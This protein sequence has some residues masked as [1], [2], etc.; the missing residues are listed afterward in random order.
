MGGYDEDDDHEE[1]EDR[2]EGELRLPRPH[3]YSND[4]LLE[5]NDGDA[6]RGGG[7]ALMDDDD[8]N[9]NVDND[10]DYRGED[11]R[12]FRRRSNSHSDYSG[13]GGGGRNHNNRHVHGRSRSR[14]PRGGGIRSSAHGGQHAAHP[15][16]RNRGEQR[17]YHGRR[18]DNRRYGYGEQF[19]GRDAVH[20]AQMVVEDINRRHQAQARHHGGDRGDPAYQAQA[21]I[22]AINRRLTSDATRQRHS[23][24]RPMQ[25]DVGEPSSGWQPPSRHHVMTNLTLR[26]NFQ[27]GLVNGSLVLWNQLPA[28]DPDLYSLAMRALVELS[29]RLGENLSASI[30]PPIQPRGGQ[31]RR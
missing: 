25:R 17:P 23:R 8:G 31:P 14:S 4:D 18:D 13:G 24:E 21:A 9:D 3:E 12:S 11:G 1:L 10:D 2:E 6:H 27:T 16:D 15:N 19:Q 29:K 7:G 26:E 28:F 5:K 22:D 30:T 20:H